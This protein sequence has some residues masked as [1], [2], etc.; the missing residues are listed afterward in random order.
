VAKATR[1][2][3]VRDRVKKKPDSQQRDNHLKRGMNYP[4]K[5]KKSGALPEGA[6]EFTVVGDVMLEDQRKKERLQVRG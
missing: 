2:D 6:R 1:K 4:L 3:P 5:K